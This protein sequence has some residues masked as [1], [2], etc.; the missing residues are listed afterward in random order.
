MSR[1]LI[2]HF[3]NHVL[4]SFVNLR[5]CCDTILGEHEVHIRCPSYLHSTSLLPVSILRRSQGEDL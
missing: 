2:F 5:L 1:M 3:N 4:I